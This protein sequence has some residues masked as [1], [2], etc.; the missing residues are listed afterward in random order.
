MKKT[1]SLIAA[2]LALTMLAACQ[3]APEEI[4]E[5]PENPTSQSSSD[6]VESASPTVPEGA[7]QSTE[8]SSESIP[9]APPEEQEVKIPDDFKLA[10]YI[11]DFEDVDYSICS[12]VSELSFAQADDAAVAKAVEAYNGSPL[13]SEVVE[14]LSEMYRYENGELVLNEEY[15]E[16]YRA[17][18]LE[19]YIDKTAA[20]AVALKTDVLK[21][22]KLGSETLESLVLLRAALP[23]SCRRWS[24]TARCYIPVY[25]SEDG[26]AH[27]LYEALDQDY[28]EFKLMY[29]DGG[30]LFAMFNFGH[31]ESGQSGAIYSFKDGKPKL[32]LSGC[33]FSIYRGIL[34]GGYGWN[35]FEPYLYDNENGGFFALAAIS[36]S[37]EPA[38]LICSD[39]LVRALVPDAWEYCQ[40]GRLQIIGGKYITFATGIPW[41]DATFI[42]NEHYKRFELTEPISVTNSPC[43]E[44][45]TRICNVKL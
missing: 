41:K 34:L 20:P 30:G 14:E 3:N 42:Y 4:S 39:N 33:P 32:E 9:E 17:Y 36:P 28:G 1:V 23:M 8:S 26:E 45:I 44:G 22:V 43:A 25:V 11:T 7:P 37:E 10:D 2:A 27:I 21:T 15:K 24:G 6:T 12:F 16:H 38:E 19:R 35:C 5:P 13:Y 18:E 40:K 31:N 29:C